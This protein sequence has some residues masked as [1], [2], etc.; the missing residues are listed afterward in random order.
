M[1]PAWNRVLPGYFYVLSLFF[2]PD[3]YR[4]FIGWSTLSLWHKF[5]VR[6]FENWMGKAQEKTT[7]NQ[8]QQ[9][10]MVSRIIHGNLV[11]WCFFFLLFDFCCCGLLPDRG[12]FYA[13]RV[14][15]VTELT[16]WEMISEKKKTN[17]LSIDRRIMRS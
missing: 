9:N 13:R 14:L 11:Q 2:L 6:H 5:R 17:I 8:R 1:E 10:K 16:S 15:S 4:V 12:P 7:K 3:Y